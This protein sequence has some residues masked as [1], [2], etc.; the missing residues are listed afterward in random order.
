MIFSGWCGD[1]GENFSRAKSAKIS[2][3]MS[4]I[5]SSFLSP[6][7]IAA[8]C[9][10]GDDG[11]VV[12]AAAP[13]PDAPPP[14]TPMPPPPPPAA[15]RDEAPEM[16]EDE[17]EEVEAEAEVPTYEDLACCAVCGEGD[18]EDGNEIVFC[19][20]CDLAVHQVCYG[21]GA[22][23]I[24]EGEKSW[25]CDVCRATPG[26]NKRGGRKNEQECIM[27]PERGGALKRTSDSRW[28]HIA[29]A[30][31]VPGVSFLDPEG[32][33]VIHPY[34]LNEKRMELAC[35]VC[36]KKMGGCIQ[37]KAPRCLTAFHPT[38]ARR[39]GLHMVT[40]EK[41]DEVDFSAWCDKHRPK[42]VVKKRR[43]KEHKW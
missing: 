27:C 2:R 29:C 5:S 30:L 21:A 37:C 19:D 17:G 1:V 3:A 34:G 8:G 25:F 16:S 36:E 22:R 35:V 23:N 42:T 38:C 31:W 24:P 4:D 18:V 6:S 26:A 41:K 15:A 20:S 39:K 13:T 10:I 7:S 11:V 33:D 28:C 12:A 9:V 43:K 40:K 14:A 32:L